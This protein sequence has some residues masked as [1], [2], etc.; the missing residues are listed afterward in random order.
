MKKELHGGVVIGV[1]VAVVLVL[2]VFAWNAIAPPGPAGL[3]SFDKAALQEMKQKHGESA[4]EIQA[5]QRRLLQ[6]GAGGAR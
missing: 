4:R 5:E 3:K 2:L 6:L 1:I